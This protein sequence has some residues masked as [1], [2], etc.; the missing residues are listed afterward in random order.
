MKA[1]KLS[2]LTAWTMTFYEDFFYTTGT[3]KKQDSCICTGTSHLKFFVVAQVIQAKASRKV[4]LKMLQL[5]S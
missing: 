5:Y 3:L 2:T 4:V 1:L